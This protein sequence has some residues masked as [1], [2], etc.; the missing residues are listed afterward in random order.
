MKIRYVDG[1]HPLEIVLADHG[2]CPYPDRS[3]NPHNYFTAAP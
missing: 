2:L 1:G 3:W